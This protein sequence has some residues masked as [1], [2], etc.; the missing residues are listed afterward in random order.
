VQRPAPDNVQHS[1]GTD[2]HA[3]GGIQT[4]NSRKQAA[5]DLCLTPHDHQEW[6]H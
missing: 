5:V 6:H 4:H 1:Q 3:S 2:I